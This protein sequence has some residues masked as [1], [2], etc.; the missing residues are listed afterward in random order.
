MQGSAPSISKSRKAGISYLPDKV[1]EELKAYIE[2]KFQTTNL[3]EFLA[4]EKNKKMYLFV[5]DDKK[6][7]LQVLY[8]EINAVRLKLREASKK[9]HIVRLN[10]ISPHFMRYSFCHN[11]QKYGFKPAEIQALMR[12]SSLNTTQRYLKLRQEEVGKQFD[13]V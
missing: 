7:S 10:L 11:L 8:N 6:K 13:E 9:A 1:V 3:D 5:L 4:N 2:R 12:H